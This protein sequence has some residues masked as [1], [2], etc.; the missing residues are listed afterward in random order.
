LKF[1]IKFKSKKIAVLFI[2]GI[3]AVVISV[4]IGVLFLTK[5]ALFIYNISSSMEQFSKD[6]RVLILAPHPDDEAIGAGG[7]IQRALSAGAKVNIICFTN[8]D[9][10]QAAFFVY[11]K[12]S[13][14]P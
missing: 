1:K 11:E 2:S 7:L 4:I 13:W 6:D 8:G 9:F 5:P 12:I 3:T 10:N 14:L